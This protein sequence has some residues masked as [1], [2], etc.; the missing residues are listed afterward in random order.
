M[1]VWV[2][3]TDNNVFYLEVS[4][5]LGVLNTPLRTRTRARAGARARV[6][7]NNNVFYLEGVSI[8]CVEFTIES[9]W[10]NCSVFI[11]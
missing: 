2:G 5:A 4:L 3:V 8:Q 11:Q 10:V 1:L 7:D 9:L 6:I